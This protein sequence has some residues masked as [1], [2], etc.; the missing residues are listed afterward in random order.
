MTETIISMVAVF[1]VEYVLFHFS[2]V[3]N[4]K[5]PSRVFITVNIIAV[6]MLLIPC[7]FKFLF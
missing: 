3:K 7:L 5:H 2:S 6:N 4:P 1:I